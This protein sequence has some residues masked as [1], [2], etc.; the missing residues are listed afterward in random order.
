MGPQNALF[1]QDT[2]TPPL[3]ISISVSPMVGLAVFGA[4]VVATGGAAGVA[5]PNVLGMAAGGATFPVIGELG[6]VVLF[7]FLRRRC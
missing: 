7:C 5:A 1:P 2:P 4:A 6:A 3:F